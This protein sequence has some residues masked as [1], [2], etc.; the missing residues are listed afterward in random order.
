MF[1]S[2]F[3]CIHPPAAPTNPNPNPNPL[4]PPLPCPYRCGHAT[5]ATAMALIAAG[6][7]SETLTFHTLS[8]AL[9]VA[10]S[11]DGLQMTLPHNAPLPLAECAGSSEVRAAAEC[12]AAVV[13][14]Q[15]AGQ[16]TVED[17]QYVFVCLSL[18][19]CVCLFHTTSHS[20][21]HT[22]PHLLSYSYSR[23]QVQ[24]RHQEACSALA[25]Q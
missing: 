9:T 7:A 3:V 2:L 25:R 22:N 15:L 13:T 6:N 23:S 16:P 1:L 4:F 24:R 18:S 10:R 8:G 19:V 20:L 5:L 12:L 21:T 14:A 11:P 17:M